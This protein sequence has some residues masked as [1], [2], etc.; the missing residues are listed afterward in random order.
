[1]AVGIKKK[2]AIFIFHGVEN[3]KWINLIIQTG[4]LESFPTIANKESKF[5]QFFNIKCIFR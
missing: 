2:G 4:N 1:M 5:N 3:K